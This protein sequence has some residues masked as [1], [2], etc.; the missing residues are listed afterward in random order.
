MQFDNFNIKLLK[1]LSNLSII[2][3]LNMK[4]KKWAELQGIS[5]LTAYRWFK[6]G[7][8]KNAKQYDS[9]TIMV[10]EENISEE[11]EDK[12]NKF[13]NEIKELL[14]EINKKIDK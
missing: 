6:A 5:Y 3:N 4:L 12:I 8:I 14:V 2:R 13:L 10:S 7:K 9:G 11:K 1:L